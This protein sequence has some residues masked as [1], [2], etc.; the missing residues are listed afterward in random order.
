L[1]ITSRIL[2]VAGLFLSGPAP[3]LAQALH[4][5]EDVRA[6]SRSHVGP[7]YLT[8]RLLLRDLGVDSNVF[9]HAEDPKSDFTFTL[10]PTLDV[11]VPV[12]SRA[13]F[14]VAASADLVYYQ[15]YSSERSL[16]PRVVPRAE[17]YLNKI[18]LFGEGSYLRS[19]QRPNFEIDERSLRTERFIGGGVGYRYSPKLSFE[20]SG[21]RADVE[22]DAGETFLSVSLRETLDR[23]SKIVAT[24][25]KYAVTPKTTLVL[26]AD[27]THDRFEFSPSRNADTVRV[28][29]GVEFGSRALIFGNAHVGVRKFDT[30]SDAL[31]NFHGVVAYAALGYTLLGRTLFVFTADRDVT[32][33]FERLQPYY[34]VDSYGITVRHRL[35]GRFDV[36]AGAGRHQYTYRDLLVEGA[37]PAANSG[38][39]RVDVT[40]SLSGS[41]GY[42][43]GPDVRIGFGTTYWQRES[44][45]AR[46][47]DYDAFRTGISLNY[48][49]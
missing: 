8:P 45:A 41:V 10:G 13:L 24:A 3:V 15:K 6:N 46:F 36:M 28:M 9:N 5:I 7:F 20:V 47:R 48:G 42:N 12:A 19:R 1:G 17:I 27:A 49:F 30:K 4:P 22:Y 21:R 34:V 35:P 31:E 43:I 44:T 29:P 11:A 39:A 25:I 16:N 32:Y 2:L 26:R 23:E 33:S 38:D 40:R 37:P 14:K 18:T